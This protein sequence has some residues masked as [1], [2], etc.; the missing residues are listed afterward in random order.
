MAVRDGTLKIYGL[1]STT[2]P[3]RAFIEAL[4]GLFCQPRVFRATDG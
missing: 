3:L 1:Q 2:T 4:S